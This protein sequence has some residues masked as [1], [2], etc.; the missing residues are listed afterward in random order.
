MQI[1]YEAKIHIE[2]EQNKISTSLWFCDEKQQK[3][4]HINNYGINQSSKHHV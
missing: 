4:K 2:M 3:P 1:S